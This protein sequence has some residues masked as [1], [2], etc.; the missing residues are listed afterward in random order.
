MANLQCLVTL[1][2]FRVVTLSRLLLRLSTNVVPL[3][4]FYALPDR[5]R[6]ALRTPFVLSVK[7]TMLGFM[8]PAMANDFFAWP[9]GVEPQPGSNLAWPLFLF[10]LAYTSRVGGCI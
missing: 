7:L 9:R 4:A 3:Y 1:S 10:K 6:A 2:Y 5:G 8:L